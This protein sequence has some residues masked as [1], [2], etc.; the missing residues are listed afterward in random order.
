MLIR[1]PEQDIERILFTEKT[2]AARVEQ[3]AGE[4]TAK[5]G[6]KRPVLVW[7]HGLGERSRL[8]VRGQ[9]GRTFTDEFDELTCVENSVIDEIAAVAEYNTYDGFDEKRHKNTHQSGE[10]CV[11]N[12]G[13]LVFTVQAFESNKL[14]RFLDERLY[15]RYSRKAFLREIRQR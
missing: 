6:D 15:D 13:V 9:L 11:I 10:A 1:T 8:L 5:Y 4:L 12:I 2:I 14:T 3:L 7:I